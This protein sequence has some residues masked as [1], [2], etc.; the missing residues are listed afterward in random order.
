MCVCRCSAFKYQT[1]SALGSCCTLWW[2]Q[3]LGWFEASCS[4]GENE[5]VV[6]TLPDLCMELHPRPHL[7]QSTFASLVAAAPFYQ[8]LGF[9]LIGAG[10]CLQIFSRILWLEWLAPC[11]IPSLPPCCYTCSLSA[12]RFS[13]SAGSSV[14]QD[15][16][17]IN[18]C[19]L[20]FSLCSI[21]AVEGDSWCPQTSKTPFPELVLDPLD[22]PVTLD[23]WLGCSHCC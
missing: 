11:C 8:R 12:F 20:F 1:P 4:L 23:R 10:M 2:G 17:T 9:A 15:H 18:L 21:V 3:H 6:S 13:L 16:L 14:R 19:P 5:P 7:P 22:N